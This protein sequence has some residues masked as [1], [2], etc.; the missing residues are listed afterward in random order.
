MK[1]II[2]SVVCLLIGVA[3]L[4]LGFIFPSY[5]TRY[6]PFG[7]GTLSVNINHPAYLMPAVY[8]VYENPEA[9]NGRYYLFKM[10]INNNGTGLIHDAK[11]SYQI[12]GFIDWTDLDTIPVLHP[13]QNAVVKC[14]PRF[15]D[16]IAEKTTESQ[17]TVN[18]KITYDDNR[19]LDEAYSFKMEG[20]NRFVYT[21]IAQQE[22]L[23]DTDWCDNEPLLACFVTPDDP[24]IKYYAQ[25]IQEK[26]MKGE[27]AGASQKPELA[28]KF[29]KEL[30][31]ATYLSHMVYSSTEDTQLNTGDITSV[32]QG[33]RLPREVVT[34]N[35]GLCVELSLLYAS[36]LKAAGL[37]AFICLIPGHA[38]PVVEVGGQDIA[39]EATGIGGEGLGGRVDADAALKRGMEELKE[40]GEKRDQGDT[41]Y[42]CLDIDALQAAGIVPMELKDDDYLRKKVDDIA[43]TFNTES[44]A[45]PQTQQ[46]AQQGDDTSN[47]S[48]D[49]GGAGLAESYDGDISFNY[50]DG[51]GRFNHPLPG[52][53]FLLSEITS[54]DGRSAINVVAVRGASQSSQAIEYIRRVIA[55]AGR[56]MVYKFASSSNGFD[57]YEGITAVNG[58][59]WDWLGVFRN[60]DDGVVGLMV[61]GAGR[62]TFQTNA[63][64]YNQILSTAH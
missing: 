47:T 26:L 64:L 36:V 41:G 39:I 48:G 56:R 21:D 50:P 34:G 52:F 16:D 11:V 22:A 32:A 49:S 60:N 29:L 7:K 13:G 44:E 53:P 17:E 45:P 61:G 37:H 24:I 35:T 10:L 38:Y 55:T 6:G 40:F 9:L 59:D 19:T 15:K 12:P 5:G 43:A 18:I 8:K 3:S 28:L 23:N 57:Y 14:Y 1:Q 62:T 63:Q 2:L 30:Y 42:T 4:A 33:I 51:W 27:E 46:V 25:Q 20:R 54:T 58:V 31:E